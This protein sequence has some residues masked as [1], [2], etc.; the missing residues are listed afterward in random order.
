M[1]DGAGYLVIRYKE[2]GSPVEI[3][4]PEEGTP[5][6]TGPSAVFKARAQPE[7]RAAVP[8]LDARAA[9]RSSSWSTGRGSIRAHGRPWRSR[10]S[11]TLARHQADEGRPGRRSR[12]KPTTIKKRYAQIFKV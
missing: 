1:V 10:A 11:G 12:R 4:Y 9:R 5:L 6:A 7:R 2:E 8:E 3:V